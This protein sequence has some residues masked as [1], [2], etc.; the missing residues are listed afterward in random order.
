MNVHSYMPSTDLNQPKPI[1]S[2]IPPIY[3]EGWY[4]GLYFKSAL[5]QDLSVC[6]LRRSN[7]DTIADEKK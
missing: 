2:Q 1:G 5:P 6:N 7:L 3:A 4:L